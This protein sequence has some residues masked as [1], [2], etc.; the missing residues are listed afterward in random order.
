MKMIVKLEDLKNKLGL[1]TLY[2]ISSNHILEILVSSRTYSDYLS[3]GRKRLNVYYQNNV[4]NPEMTSFKTNI[5]TSSNPNT[6]LSILVDMTGRTSR[7]KSI[8]ATLNERE[9][10]KDNP[11]F[12]DNCLNIGCNLITPTVNVNVKFAKT[13]E[14]LVNFLNNKDYYFFNEDTGKIMYENT[15]PTLKIKGILYD[16]DQTI[17]NIDFELNVFGKKITQEDIY[18]YNNKYYIKDIFDDKEDLI[19]FKIE[20]HKKTIAYLEECRGNNK[21][22][23]LIR[24]KS[25]RY[26]F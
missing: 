13:F 17:L 16:V 6:I 9:K 8:E 21:E 18:Y 11:K 14:D 3:T 22:G 1:K 7:Y 2:P 10:N 12:Y 25:D 20:E 24:G 15:S 4:T 23:M 19:N 26:K 5:S